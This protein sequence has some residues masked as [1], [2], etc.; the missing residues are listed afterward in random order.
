M[1]VNDPLEQAYAR[2]MTVR[3]SIELVRERL[4]KIGIDPALVPR[5]GVRPDKTWERFHRNRSGE[6]ERKPYA[7]YEFKVTKE[8]A[9]VPQQTWLGVFAAVRSLDRAEGAVQ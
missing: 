3:E 9:R 1:T 6:R 2:L 4:R 5:Y 8:R 7:P